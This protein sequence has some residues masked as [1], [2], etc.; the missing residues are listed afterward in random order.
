MW[1]H[2]AHE[3]SLSFFDKLYKFITIS[4]KCTHLNDDKTDMILVYGEYLKNASPS[5]T[6]IK[7]IEESFE[8]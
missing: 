8:S 4:A 6:I 1:I 2:D 7:K 5:D 3:S